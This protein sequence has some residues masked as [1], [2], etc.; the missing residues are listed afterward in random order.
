MLLSLIYRATQLYL[1]QSDLDIAVLWEFVPSKR[2]R[3]KKKSW[4]EHDYNEKP[5]EWNKEIIKIELS[6]L[7]RY[8]NKCSEFKCAQTILSAKVPIIKLYD[9]KTNLKVD[10]SINEKD[11][12]SAV[13]FIKQYKKLYPDMRIIVFILKCILKSRE[14]NETFTGGISSYILSLLV[15]SYF[16]E[17]SKIKE[18]ENLRTWEHLLNFLELFSIKFNYKYV[19]ISLR[20]GGSYFPRPDIDSECVVQIRNDNPVLFLEKPQDITK[21]LGDSVKKMNEII[22]VFR[23]VYMTLKYHSGGGSTKSF[24]KSIIHDDISIHKTLL[25]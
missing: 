24:L 9:A 3:N 19:G 14:L 2:K 6:Q 21:N 13:G 7:W 10:I 8:F 11:G 22:S 4:D 15:I 17:S 12:V 23:H 25:I 20:N 16:Q 1:P 5:E 18:N